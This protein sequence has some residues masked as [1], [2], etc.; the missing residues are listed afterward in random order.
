MVADREINTGGGS[1]IGG[2][3]ESGR[4]VIGRDQIIQNIVV[5]GQFLDFAKVSDLLPK[6]GEVTSFDQIS[7]AF[8]D[9][10][11]DEAGQDLAYATSFAG[12][13]LRD[14]VLELRPEDQFAAFPYAKMLN[15]LA[16]AV[17]DKL[18]NLGHWD[19]NSTPLDD[20]LAKLLRFTISSKPRIVWLT[21]LEQL[22]ED[23]FSYESR[24]GFLEGREYY[25]SKNS[26]AMVFFGP[27][28]TGKIEDHDWGQDYL[29]TIF[30]GVV[31]DLVRI[32]S[33]HSSDKQ[34]WKRLVKFLGSQP[35][36]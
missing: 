14:L 3:V 25:S 27:Q 1:Y 15:D 12:E 33:L 24:F 28:S 31:I 22:W 2:D 36:K 6:P 26:R 10:F 23:R 21:S 30:A 5:V 7:A 35:R 8:E 11:G 19:V 13:I 17:I 4:D 16:P 29:H 32:G 18:H 9:T 20:E 34:F